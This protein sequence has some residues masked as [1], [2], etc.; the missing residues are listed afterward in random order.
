[1]RI[2]LAYDG[3]RGADAALDDLAR[4]GLPAT[5]EALVLA[6]ADVPWDATPPERGPLG[7]FAAGRH[8]RGRGWFAL[9][10]ALAAAA[11]GESRVRAALPGWH[12]TH[13]GLV[14]DAATVVMDR[15]DAWRPDLVVVGSHA[16]ATTAHRSFGSVARRIV[17]SAHC[18][19]RVGRPRSAEAA[20]R[21][22]VRIVLGTDGSPDAE[23]ALAAVAARNWPSGS[24]AVV[25]CAVDPVLASLDAP[26]GGTETVPWKVLRDLVHAAAERLHGGGLAAAPHLTEGDARKVLV[27]E[28]ERLAADAIVVGARGRG[29]SDATSL[30]GGVAASVVARAPCSVEIV[31]G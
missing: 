25:V 17:T 10:D 18:S 31:R 9:E 16:V 22:G 26:E 12:V 8:G 4:A 3:T 20:R 23:A 28:A 5:G 27:T 6:A 14:G 15:A 30:L 21:A 19:V 7:A 1:M 29:R 11:R 13:E 2:L 24:A